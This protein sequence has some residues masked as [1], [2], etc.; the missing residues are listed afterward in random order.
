MRCYL[1]KILGERREKIAVVSRKTGINV[2]TLYRLYNETATRVDLEV[3][4]TL[5]NYLE[6]EIGELFEME[7]RKG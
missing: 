2:N 4:E 1:S 5:C 6:I 3:I 7:K